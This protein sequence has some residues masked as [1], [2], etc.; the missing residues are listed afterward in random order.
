MLRIKEHN[1][2]YH[3]SI[4]NECKHLIEVLLDPN[5]EHRIKVKDIFN[6][7]FIKK[8]TCTMVKAPPLPIPAHPKRHSDK[9]LENFNTIAISSRAN[10]VTSLKRGLLCKSNSFNK[11]TKSKQISNSSAN[12][13]IIDEVKCVLSR[14]RSKAKDQINQMCK[15]FSN[16]NVQCQQYSCFEDFRAVNNNNNSASNINNTETNESNV[17][18]KKKQI[19]MK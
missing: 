6:H 16:S 1:I 18:H 4:S 17:L 13:S 11:D 7:S 12:S 8:H 14:E 10:A 15:Q 3:K 9:K 5:P 19:N 2:V